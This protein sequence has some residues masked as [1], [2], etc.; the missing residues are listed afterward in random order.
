MPLII[1]GK[2]ID[3]PSTS[4]FPPFPEGLGVGVTIIELVVIQNPFFLFLIKLCLKNVF[5]LVVEKSFRHIRSCLCPWP[6]Q[7]SAYKTGI[8]L[9]AAHKF[10]FESV[11]GA[12][13]KFRK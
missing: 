2:I 12:R 11:P 6:P 9:L 1:L 8:R 3:T 4:S 5:F 13:G 10:P 7:N